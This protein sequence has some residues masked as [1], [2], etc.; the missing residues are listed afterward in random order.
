MILTETTLK[1]VWIVEPEP[2]QDHRGK[3][4]RL[5]CQNELSEILRGKTIKQINY[6]VTQ[7]TGTVRGM[8]FQKPPMAETKIVSCLQGSVMDVVVDLRRDSSSFLGWYGAILSR[9][10]TKMLCVPEGFAHG[11]QAL[12]NNCEML[13]FHTEFFSPKHEK[14]IRYNDPMIEIEWPL[15]ITEISDRDRNHPLLPYEFSGIDV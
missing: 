12:E 9:E 10:N 4:A 1:G 3:L 15:E 5:F 2:V 13:Y 8:H 6:T 7:K 11:F 14:G